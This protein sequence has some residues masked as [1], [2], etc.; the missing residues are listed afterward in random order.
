MLQNKYHCDKKQSKEQSW[1]RAVDWIG[2]NN[3]NNSH[4]TVGAKNTIQSVFREFA[5]VRLLYEI[6]SKFNKFT[7]FLRTVYATVQVP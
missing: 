6:I 4:S 3:V 2:A 5:R 7:T 1:L